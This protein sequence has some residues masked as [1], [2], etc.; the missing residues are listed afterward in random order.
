MEL[1]LC[2]ILTHYTAH[3]DVTVDNR[4]YVYKQTF[5]QK[6]FFFYCASAPRGPGP[7]HYQGLKITLGPAIRRTPLDE[8]SV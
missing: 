7:P 4:V 8:P 6:N 3:G 1:I 5:T 2:V